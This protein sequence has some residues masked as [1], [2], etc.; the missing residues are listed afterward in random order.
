MKRMKERPQ[1]NARFVLI[2]LLLPVLALG[3]IEGSLRLLGYGN[4]LALF[5]PAPPGLADRELLRVNPDIA[6]R[7][8]TE[9]RLV[10]RPLPD[11][12]MLRKP[13]NGYRIFVM[14]ESATAGFPYPGNMAF[15]RILQG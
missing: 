3:L 12:F 14:G 7:Y 6:R 9:S 15:S 10:P 8:F 11:F 13:A 5:V 2:A 1:G 4:D